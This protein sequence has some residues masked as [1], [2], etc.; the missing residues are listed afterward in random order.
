MNVQQEI[1]RSL[2]HE[3]GQV[4]VAP[5][6]V[7]DLTLLGDGLVPTDA[8]ARITIPAAVFSGEKSPPFLRNSARAVAQALSKGKDI[9]LAGQN[10]N[11]SAKALTPSL[12]AFL[13]GK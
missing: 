8:L 10:H 7:Y 9:P 6:L 4:Q 2:C 13:L 11:L 12:E 3:A 5:T 1:M